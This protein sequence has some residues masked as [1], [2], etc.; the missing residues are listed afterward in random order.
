MI[1]QNKVQQ[2][3]KEDC[4]GQTVTYHNTESYTTITFNNPFIAALKGDKPAHLLN[5]HII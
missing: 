3:K 2:Q 1:T 5:W 4:E